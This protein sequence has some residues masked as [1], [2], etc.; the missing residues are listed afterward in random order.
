MANHLEGIENDGLQWCRNKSFSIRNCNIC[1]VKLYSSLTLAVNLFH[2]DCY[3]HQC[4][5][6]LTGMTA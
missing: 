3:F 4:L 6:P 1:N 2:S 5:F